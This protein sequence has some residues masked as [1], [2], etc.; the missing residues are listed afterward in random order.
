LQ[1]AIGLGQSVIKPG[2]ILNRLLV[3][4]ALAERFGSHAAVAAE[5]IDFKHE[6]YS[7]I[8]EDSVWQFV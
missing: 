4:A 8:Q 6:I 3:A 1:G 2:A 7:R 5:K